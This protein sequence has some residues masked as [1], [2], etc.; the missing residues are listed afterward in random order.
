M[1]NITL[2]I[3]EDTLKLGRDYARKHRVSLNVL[4]R[5][6]LEQTIKAS[7]S[8]WLDDTFSLIDAKKVTSDGKKW[9]REDL[10]R[11]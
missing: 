7:S 4:I 1:K 2:A 3:D 9:K 8:Q 11:A 5:R 6:L 10:Y